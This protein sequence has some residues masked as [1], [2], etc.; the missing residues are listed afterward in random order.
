MLKI[1]V[2]EYNSAASTEENT[3][4]CGIYADK[5]CVILSI[6]ANKGNAA[7][8]KGAAVRRGQLL[9][10]G[11]ITPEGS[12]ERVLVHSRGTITGQVAYRFSVEIG[13]TAPKLCQSGTSC[14]YELTDT[15]STADAGN[16]LNG[17][18]VVDEPTVTEFTEIESMDEIIKL[19]GV[20]DENL[21]IIEAE[22][23]TNIAA[24]SEK[25][26][27]SGKQSAVDIARNVVE[28][29]LSL[30]KRGE[31][32][33]RGRIRYAIDLAR[34]GNSEL[35]LEL[36]DDVIAF[37]SKGKQIKCKTLGQKRYINALKHN[38][39]VFGVGPAGTGKTY[40][41][42]AMAVL[43]YK[44]KEVSRI[45]LTRPAVEAGEKLGFL[46]GDLQNKVD[47]YLRPLYDALYD[48]LGSENFRILSE[49]GVIE[50]APLA[51]MRGRTLND[52]YI[53]LDE[54]QN[55]TVEQMK[56][57]LTRFGEGSRVVV[58]GDITQ[59]DL[60]RE[61]TSGL[62]HAL[63]VLNEVEGLSI[64]YLTARDVVRH[65]MVQRIVRA[66][67]KSGGTCRRTCGGAR[68]CRP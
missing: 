42:V 51:Y 32:I 29:L 53:I 45:I 50:V 37:T 24:D 36:A 19:F 10:N 33:D 2:S 11:D 49:R 39:V 3:E 65:E 14:E 12:S 55:C 21:K 31:S 47:P 58:T 28:K 17:K 6:V 54:A 66:Y 48:F 23:G 34:E 22:T 63:R 4:P 13:K 8:R 35:I 7:V 1:N 44:N 30:I 43:A 62:I 52:A 59:I 60:P 27:I 64:V 5:D 41:A 16:M 56:M 38:T 25:I 9:I 15:E 61:K 20:F 40:L 18:A 68:C 57:F 67:E 26:N 46:P